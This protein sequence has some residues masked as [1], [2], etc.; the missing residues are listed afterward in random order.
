MGCAL[1][2][3]KFEPP[4]GPRFLCWRHSL[5]TFPAFC[6]LRFQKRGHGLWLGISPCTHRLF[7]PRS[8]VWDEALFRHMS[9]VARRLEPVLPSPP[10]PAPFPVPPSLFPALSALPHPPA[11]IVPFIIPPPPPLP[12]SQRS[13]LSLLFTAY[14]LPFLSLLSFPIFRSLFCFVRPNL[15]FSFKHDTG[16]RLRSFVCVFAVVL[17]TLKSLEMATWRRIMGR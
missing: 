11:P 10:P 17:C 7:A 5:E 4:P 6:S 3:S 15:F 14:I 2:F 16:L 13:A 12:N 1:N 8:G 9:A